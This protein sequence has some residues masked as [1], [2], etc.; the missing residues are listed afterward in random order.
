M[1]R[2][3]SF[4]LGLALALFWWI[5][6]QLDRSATILWFDA[7]AAILS[8]AVGGLVDDE[9]PASAH[10]APPA[11]LGLG[12]AVLWIAGT[13]G[14]QPAWVNWLNLFFGLTYLAV[15]AIT[16]WKPDFR[17]AWHPTRSPRA[18]R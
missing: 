2:I 8:F 14:G 1:V 11:L 7:V 5:G 9:H 13:A 16:A 3:S 18:R 15:A 17:P 6:L 4:V 10:A 12:L